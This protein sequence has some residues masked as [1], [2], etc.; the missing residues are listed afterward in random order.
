MFWKLLTW[1]VTIP[2]VARWIIRIFG[3][4]N[5]TYFHIANPLDPQ[6]IY[7]HRYW[8][9]KRRPWW[10]FCV[11]LHHINREDMDRNMHSHPFNYRTIILDGYYWEERPAIEQSDLRRIPHLLMAGDTVAN[12]IGS[13]HRI[14]DVSYSGVWTL[15]FMWGGDKGDWGFLTPTGYVRA[16]EYFETHK[17]PR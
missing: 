9:W 4:E 13:F 10:N 2:F 16:K 6:D 1:F 7:M 17:A 15:F 8:V 5:H 3:N 12:T 11:R 14:T